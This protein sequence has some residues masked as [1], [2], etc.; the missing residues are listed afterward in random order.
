MKKTLKIII[1]FSI[2]LFATGMTVFA[3]TLTTTIGAAIK[4]SAVSADEANKK[5][6]N[7]ILGIL[8]F[9]GVAV[10]FVSILLMGIKYVTT[11]ADVKAELKTNMIGLLVGGFLV[12]IPMTIIGFI[13]T[14]SLTQS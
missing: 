1:A 10:M 4:P 11:Q 5:L 6:F 14:I 13:K 7:Q 3:S 2:L 12:F 8:Q 9:I